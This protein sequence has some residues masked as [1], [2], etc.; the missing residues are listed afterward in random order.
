MLKYST[1]EQKGAVT[2]LAMLVIGFVGAVVGMIAQ[3][4][5][6]SRTLAYTLAFL[7]LF[8]ILGLILLPVYAQKRLEKAQENMLIIATCDGQRNV[9]LKVENWR[10]F[11]DESIT[12]N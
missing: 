2:G 8:H 1:T 10:M 3:F 9:M 11:A 7:L 5:H 4:T 12:V 6:G